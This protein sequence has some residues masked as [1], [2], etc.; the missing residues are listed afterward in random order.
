MNLTP[1]D[2]RTYL[3]PRAIEELVQLIWCSTTRTAGEPRDPPDAVA[4]DGRRRRGVVAAECRSPRTPPAAW[5][6]TSS[7]PASSVP[8]RCRW[9]S[10]VPY[11]DTLV[12]PRSAQEYGVPTNGASKRQVSESPAGAPGTVVDR[13]DMSAALGTGLFVGNLWY[14][15]SPTRAACRTDGVTRFATFWIDDGEIVAPVNVLRF[16]DTA[17]HLLGDRLEGLTDEAEVLLDA[18]SYGERSTSSARLPGALVG[19]M[20]FVLYLTHRVAV[21]GGGPQRYG[22]RHEEASPHHCHHRR[23]RRRRC[24]VPP[25]RRRRPEPRRPPPPSSTFTQQAK[26]KVQPAADKA[27]DAVED[28]AD[29]AADAVGDA[30]TP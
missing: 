18:A 4:A 22:R 5:R 20:R 15:T 12:S 14:T 8:I 26:D 9:S 11:T 10:T 2:P 19:A 21:G 23:G 27:A 3:A 7:R 25:R 30:P 6:R 28:A 29:D 17:F 13:V 24:C 1:G 16:D